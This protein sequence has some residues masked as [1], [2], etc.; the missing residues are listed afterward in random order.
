MPLSLREEGQIEFSSAG[1]LQE[2]KC[3][4]AEKVKEEILKKT[5]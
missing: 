5:N 2:K 4:K 1:F 3:P